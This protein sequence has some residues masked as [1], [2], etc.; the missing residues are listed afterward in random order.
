VTPPPETREPITADGDLPPET[1]ER[2]TADGD[3]LPEIIRA[4]IFGEL[5]YDQ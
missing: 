1:R 5:A 3:L 4:Y 2:I